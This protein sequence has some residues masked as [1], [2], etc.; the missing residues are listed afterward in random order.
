MEN[1]TVYLDTCIISGIAEMD[2]PDNDIDALINIFEQSKK[3]KIKIATSLISKE[4]IG[5]IPIKYRKKHELIYYLLTD[6]TYFNYLKP[7]MNYG[8]T[9]IGCGVGVGFSSHLKRKVDP[10]LNKLKLLLPDKNDALHIFQAAKNK[11]QYF[12]TV[13]RKTILRFENQI[14]EICKI[15]VIRP[16]E[17]NTTFLATQK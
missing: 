4:E 1:V 16:Q 10:I 15:K 14:E 5:K 13:D 7:I 12:L 9:I 6:L 11:I 17:F 3:G 2:L 8:S